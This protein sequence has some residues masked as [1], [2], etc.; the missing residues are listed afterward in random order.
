[1]AFEASNQTHQQIY[2]SFGTGYPYEAKYHNIGQLQTPYQGKF[3]GQGGDYGPPQSTRYY[4]VQNPTYP[5]PLDRDMRPARYNP[6]EESCYG[7]P[8][9]SPCE[10]E[11][12]PNNFVPPNYFTPDTVWATGHAQP[13]N[14]WT[15]HIHSGTSMAYST[16]GPDKVKWKNEIGHMVLPHDF[17][18]DGH[19]VAPRGNVHNSSNPTPNTRSN[20]DSKETFMYE[21][22]LMANNPLIYTTDYQYY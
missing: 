12:Y 9:Y 16:T 10:E 2:P 8:G 6:T 21:K 1:M 7:H 19:N 15:D 13:T 4:T 11:R 22:L 17:V 14:K 3:F 20:Q 18:P 5:Y